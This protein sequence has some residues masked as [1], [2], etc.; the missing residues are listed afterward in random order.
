MYPLLSCLEG[1][2]RI[3]RSTG[4]TMRI[5]APQASPKCQTCAILYSVMQRIFLLVGFFLLFFFVQTTHAQEF[6]FLVNQ[7]LWISKT[8][9]FAG[10]KV[11]IYTVVVNNDF[12]SL[13]AEVVFFADGVHI[14]SDFISKLAFEQAEQVSIDY[15]LKEGDQVLEARLINIQ[16]T[17]SGGQS[18][19]FSQEQI[20]NY[21]ATRSFT[22]DL[23]TDGDDVG[24]KEDTDDDNDALSDS[25]E[26]VRG[27]DPLKPDTDNDTLSD[28]KEVDA[29]TDP[30]KADSDGDGK[31]DGEDVFPT[32]SE[33]WA[34]ADGDGIGD[35]S[36]NDDDNDGLSDPDEVAFQSDPRN[37]DT[38]GDGLTD[39]EEKKY[40]SNP[41]AKDSDGDGIDDFAEVA[42]GTNPASDDSDG[43]GIRDNEEKKH[44]TDP[45]N[46]DTDG[47]GLLDGEELEKGTDPTDVDSDDDGVN[48]LL[49]AFPLNAA[50]ARDT[51]L[52]GI[53]NNEDADD[54]GDG[55]LDEEEHILGTD[56]LNAD[57]DGDGISDNLEKEQ[58]LN[59]T[60][61][62]TDGD[63]KK[64]GEDKEPLVANA[65]TVKRAVQFGALASFLL[66]LVFTSLYAYRREH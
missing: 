46:K 22:I 18:A 24:N 48:D 25:D 7:S 28:K 54:D 10:D 4:A 57:T 44:K 2:T 60:E 26:G 62:D 23:D 38:D 14:G 65:F 40:G 55:L 51:D 3:L 29:G 21:Q 5:G 63:G 49:D 11:K 50:E 20:K 13:S 45:K 31:K 66:F 1:G 35:N 6:N 42:A 56:S 53:G 61:P 15:A 59:P 43:D 17:D 39:L 37:P 47:D 34:D 32:N 58:G 12:T 64:D 52:D 36:D 30:L 9:A 27:T 8:N 19:T 41:N 16:A 33:E